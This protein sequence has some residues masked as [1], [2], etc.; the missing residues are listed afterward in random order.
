MSSNAKPLKQWYH[1]HKLR[2]T[3][4]K[5]F[6]RQSI[7]NRKIVGK[8]VFTRLLLA[9]NIGQIMDILRLTACMV[10]NQNIVDNFVSLCNC[11][12]MGWSYDNEAPSSQMK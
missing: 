6:R 12:T 8:I 10:V 1:Y 2:K 5:F 3:F 4:Y 11:T 9:K 7:K